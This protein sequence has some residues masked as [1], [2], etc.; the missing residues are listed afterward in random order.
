MTEDSCSCKVQVLAHAYVAAGTL[1]L[2]HMA[3]LVLFR[4]VLMSA[5]CNMLDKYY[6]GLQPGDQRIARLEST[7][8]EQQHQL[9]PVLSLFVSPQCTNQ[10]KK[11]NMT[12]RR[13]CKRLECNV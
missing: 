1:M 10:M 11:S 13:I 9:K 6:K 3:L 7:Q 2:G 4:K 8:K 12:S 5:H